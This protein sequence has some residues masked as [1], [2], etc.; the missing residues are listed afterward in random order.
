[1]RI[2]GKE[3]L[4]MGKSTVTFALTL[5]VLVL[6]GPLLLS[7]PAAAAPRA[8]VAGM[9]KDF[10]EVFEDQELVHTFVIRNVG[11]APLHIKDIEPDCACT[12]AAYTRLIP[13]G[14][15]GKITLTLAPYSVLKKFAKHTEVTLNDPQRP[16]VTLTLQGWGKPVIDIQPHHIIRFQGKPGEALTARVRLVSHLKTPWEVGAPKTDIPH[17]VACSLTAEVPGKIYLLEIKNKSQ[18]VGRYA[19]KIEMSTNAPHRPKL[20]LRVFGDL[21]PSGRPQE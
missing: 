17:L 15:E 12:A 7:P 9:V 2:K 8:E 16:K 18:Q 14:G 20:V 11:D 5:C 3:N 6:S 13:P 10:G 4:F 21:T 19:G 1:M